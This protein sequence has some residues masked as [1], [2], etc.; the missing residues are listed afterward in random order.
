MKRERREGQDR[1]NANTESSN[2]LP[3]EWE[4]KRKWKLHR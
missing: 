1:E 3:R 2:G 4:S